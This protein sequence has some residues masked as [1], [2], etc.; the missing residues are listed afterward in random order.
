M[1]KLNTI[2]IEKFGKR[3]YF[4]VENYE[5]SCKE[6]ESNNKSSEYT[7]LVDYSNFVDIKNIIVDDNSINSTNLEEFI[8]FNR[9]LD[10]EVQ[11]KSIAYFYNVTCSNETRNPLAILENYMSKWY[12]CKHLICEDDINLTKNAIEKLKDERI[13]LYLDNYQTLNMV[14]SFIIDKKKIVFPCSA[15]INDLYMNADGEIHKCIYDSNKFELNKVYTYSV[16]DSN[17]CSSCKLKYICGG[18]CNNYI[19]KN[20]EMCNILHEIISIILYTCIV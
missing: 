18:M 11:I 10:K 15:G 3:I 9:L 4:D 16:D 12:R 19:N 2:H 1:N 17:I 8:E 20:L 5:I 7:R 13:D 6:I 14:R